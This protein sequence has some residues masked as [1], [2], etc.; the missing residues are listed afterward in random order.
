LQALNRAGRF[1][2]AVLSF[3]CLPFPSFADGCSERYQ[4]DT[5]SILPEFW[6][7]VVFHHAA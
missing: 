7:V 3:P 1:A 6:L 4:K 2:N 5:K